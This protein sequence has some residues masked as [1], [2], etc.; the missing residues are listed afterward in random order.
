MGGRCVESVI[1]NVSYVV[2]GTP[3]GQKICM[4]ANP[5]DGC[6]RRRLNIQKCDG[7]SGRCTI[8]IAWAESFGGEGELGSDPCP[9]IVKNVLDIQYTCSHNGATKDADPGDFR[10]PMDGGCEARLLGTAVLSCP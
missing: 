2:E 1:R 7:Q 10:P 9:F 3:D 4:N 6:A 8:K 5:P